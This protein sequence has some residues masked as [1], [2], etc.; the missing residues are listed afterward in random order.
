MALNGLNH[1]TLLVK[2]LDRAEAFYSGLLG[3]EQVGTRGNFMRFYS[4]GRQA[5]ELALMADPTFT[6]P[7]QGVAHIGWNVKDEKTLKQLF[8]KLKSAG[9]PMSG[10]VDHVIAHS[11]YVRDPDGYLVEITL[12]RPASDWQDNDTAFEQDFAL[13]LDG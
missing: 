8:E 7:G 6:A 4:S 2:N 1:I 3:L 9:C 11:F 13:D 12:D 10:G 5:H